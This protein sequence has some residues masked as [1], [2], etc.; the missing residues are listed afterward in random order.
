MAGTLFP[1]LGGLK[2]TVVAKQQ[3]KHCFHP[4]THLATFVDTEFDCLHTH[5]HRLDKLDRPLRQ[6]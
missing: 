5:V 2:D 1:A 4:C 3:S 6:I